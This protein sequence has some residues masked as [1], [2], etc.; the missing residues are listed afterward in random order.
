MSDSTAPKSE[1]V[2]PVDAL[3]ALLAQK[4]DEIEAAADTS[5]ETAEPEPIP[6]DV[7]RFVT[8]R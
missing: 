5:P 4:L 7:P 2:H 8:W 6:P 1:P 3:L